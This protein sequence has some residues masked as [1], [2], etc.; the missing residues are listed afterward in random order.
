MADSHIYLQLDQVRRPLEPPFGGP[1]WVVSR[2]TETFRIQRGTRG[3]VNLDRLRDA[4]LDTPLGLVSSLLLAIPSVS[5]HDAFGLT[6]GTAAVRSIDRRCIVMLSFCPPHAPGQV[7]AG[8][9]RGSSLVPRELE[10][11][12]RC[13]FAD[14]QQADTNHD[15]TKTHIRA[16]G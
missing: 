10:A 12:Q 1:F 2:G 16:G 7:A 8:T 13:P 3:V 4:V 11:N 5:P 15:R 14:W 9:A 6:G